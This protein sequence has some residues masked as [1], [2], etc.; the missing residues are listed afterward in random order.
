MFFFHTN[1]VK[2]HTK[3]NP[4]SLCNLGLGVGGEF[5]PGTLKGCVLKRQ[6]KCSGVWERGRW[7]TSGQ[8]AE[9]VAKATGR[10]PLLS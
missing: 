4:D 8:S 6:I 1:K 9:E 10:G 3:V 2:S 7:T 5:S